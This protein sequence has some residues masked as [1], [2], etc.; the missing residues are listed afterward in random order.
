[1]DYPGT[2]FTILV[3]TVSAIQ[4]VQDH[5]DGT[6]D[7]LKNVTETALETNQNVHVIHVL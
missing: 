7:V 3:S 5:E 4:H 2:T 6:L 1:M